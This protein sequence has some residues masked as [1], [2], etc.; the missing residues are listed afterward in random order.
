MNQS[1]Q[2]SAEL[3]PEVQ[4]PI[5]RPAA[6]D[7][8]VHEERHP[9]ESRIY[10]SS[11]QESDSDA[12]GE[13]D[14]KVSWRNLPPPSH[15]ERLPRL[16]LPI[17]IPQRRP[18]TKTR[19]FARV[20]PPIL[21]TKGIPVVEVCGVGFDRE[22][23]SMCLSRLPVSIFLEGV[24]QGNVDL[25]S[26]HCAQLGDLRRGIHPNMGSSRRNRHCP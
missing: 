6:S 14:D 9:D 10:D 17:V 22:V 23:I 15:P 20:Y 12:E 5:V 4:H 16:E 8:G 21:E 11:D 19:G 1:S 18:G 26:R 13:G 2:R 24:S 7:P 25:A 3:H